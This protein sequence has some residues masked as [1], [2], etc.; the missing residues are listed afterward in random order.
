MKVICI[1]NC[2][3]ENEL[4]IGKIYDVEDYSGNLYSVFNCESNNNYLDENVGYD[5]NGNS[6]YYKHYFKLLS[7]SRNEKLKK[8]GV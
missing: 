4:E 7:D 8:L 6:V 5:V 3:V 2:Y 1:E